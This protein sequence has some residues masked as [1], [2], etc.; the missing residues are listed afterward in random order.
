MKWLRTFSSSTL[1]LLALASAAPAS[2]HG[3][4]RGYGHGYYGSRLGFGIGLGVGIALSPY[5]SYYSPYY[6]SAY[7][8]NPYY[9]RPYYPYNRE[10]V[11]NTVYTSAP[12]T[13]YS[14]QS[15]AVISGQSQ[16]QSTSY[17]SGPESGDT[18]SWYYCHNPDGFYPSI[19][20]CSSGWQRVAKQAPT[21][22]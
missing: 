17:A 11:V 3:Y 10:V 5:P 12:P 4:G 16:S 22:R 19:K 9:A 18:S 7:Y 20:A 14:E 8:G 21:E 15:Y 1:I 6:G 13:V 2:A